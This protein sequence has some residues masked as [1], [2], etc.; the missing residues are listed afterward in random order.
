MNYDP[1]TGEPIVHQYNGQQAPSNQS[2]PFAIAGLICAI[3]VGPILGIILSIIGFN[4]SKSMNGEGK[5]L[6]LAGIIVSIVKF[7]LIII[8][9]V[10]CV[11]IF[12]VSAKEVSSALTCY[13]AYDCSEP[14][15]N[16]VAKCKYKY[17]DGTVKTIRCDKGTIKTTKTT[18]K[19]SYSA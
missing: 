19:N 14:N 5:G 17:L 12:S 16:G 6:A 18:K 7:V 2:N 1:N 3:V 11:I 8:L 10:I 13:Y 4:K 9:T 15:K